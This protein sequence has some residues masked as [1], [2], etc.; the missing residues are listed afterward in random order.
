ML[1]RIFLLKPETS[2]FHVI[3]ITIL[4]YCIIVLESKIVFFRVIKVIKRKCK[5]SKSRYL[6]IMSAKTEH[7]L[8]PI[9]SDPVPTTQ[10]DPFFSVM[11]YPLFFIFLFLFFLCPFSSHSRSRYFTIPL[12]SNVS[13][14][15]IVHVVDISRLACHQC[16]L[17]SERNSCLDFFFLFYLFISRKTR[18]F[19]TIC[20]VLC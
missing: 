11:P 18:I 13:S 1:K 6:K 3:M 8:D 9:R 5:P 10:E 19:F 14:G 12:R 4:Y 17:V 15:V 16:L 20:L 2:T 7:R